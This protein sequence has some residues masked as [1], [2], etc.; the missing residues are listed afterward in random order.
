MERNSILGNLFI[1]LSVSFTTVNWRWA[2]SAKG[3]A[4]GKNIQVRTGFEPFD[5][6]DNDNDSK[7]LEN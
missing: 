6:D 3:K 4:Y 5:N 1:F 2:M 7:N